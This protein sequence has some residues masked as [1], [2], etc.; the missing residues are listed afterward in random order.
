MLQLESSI[1][2]FLALAAQYTCEIRGPAALEQATE[3]FILRTSLLQG[4][5]MADVLTFAHYVYRTCA[6]WYS[7]PRCHDIPCASCLSRYS[8]SVWPIFLEISLTH[9]YLARGNP[10]Q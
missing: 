5:K 9:E 10:Y 7:I 3:D 4:V 8:M 6:Q 2:D 1:N